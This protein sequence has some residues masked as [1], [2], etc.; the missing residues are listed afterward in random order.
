MV[1][2]L[3]AAQR[4]RLPI[5]NLLASVA[6]LT[7]LIMGPN[8]ASTSRS[9]ADEAEPANKPKLALA[10][11]QAYLPT[12]L[13]KA[14]VENARHQI[15]ALQELLRVL[16][17]LEEGGDVS[18][19]PLWAAEEVLLRCRLELLQRETA[20]RDSLDQFT[21]RFS[22]PP[23]RLQEIE[24]ATLLPLTQHARRYEN[25][26]KEVEAACEDVS[27]KDDPEMATKLR[28][29]IREVLSNS[30][31]VKGTKFGTQGPRRWDAWEELDKANDHKAINDRLKRLGDERQK[32]LDLQ[33][34]SE[35][36]HQTLAPADV[37]RL[38][39][40]EFEIAVGNLELELRNYEAQRQWRGPKPRLWKDIK[41]PTIRRRAQMD[42]FHQVYF[43]FV[44][45]LLEARNER[46]QEASQSWPALPALQWDGKDLLS[47]DLEQ[48]ERT[49]ASLFLKPD[50]ALAGKA[51]LRKLRRLAESYKVEQRL[52]ELSLLSKESYREQL[53]APPSPAE[54]AEPPE[55]TASAPQGKQGGGEAAVPQL[56][57]AQRSLGRN[58]AQLLSTW[59][60]YQAARLDFYVSQGGTP[61]NK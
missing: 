42:Q 2:R 6:A 14:Q 54:S 23:K 3:R 22:V 36:K 61:P 35:L 5:P 51:K 44:A 19:L 10:Q 17:A 34:D 40:D 27:K 20:Y 32:L 39:E 45:V 58:T 25:L 55:E 60:T 31:L 9:L 8:V 26:F 52:F 59:I 38:K 30:A 41:D 47:C 46:L 33:A 57:A 48:A 37:Q 16:R 24:E 11:L 43:A 18:K 4:R 7:L 15:A 1:R 28:R 21:I 50:A 13:Q 12:L 29:A 53:I 49:V 56:L